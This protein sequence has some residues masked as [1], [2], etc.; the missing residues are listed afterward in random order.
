MKQTNVSNYNLFW[1]FLSFS[2]FYSMKNCFLISHKCVFALSNPHRLFLKC[3]QVSQMLLFVRAL[4]FY[5][6]LH[7]ELPVILRCLVQICLL[8]IPSAIKNTLY[9]QTHSVSII[10]STYRRVISARGRMSDV[11]TFQLAAQKNA[12]S[13]SKIQTSWFGA[14]GWMRQKASAIILRRVKKNLDWDAAWRHQH[15]SL[16]PCHLHQP[17]VNRNLFHCSTHPTISGFYSS[18][19][20]PPPN[21]AVICLCFHLFM[22]D[23]QVVSNDV[24]AASLLKH[25]RVILTFGRDFISES[26]QCSGSCQGDYCVA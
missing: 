6:E 3:Q 23:T 10:Q 12:L 7:G 21:M 13:S 8:K 4:T 16:S 19:C 22:P 5:C 24:F 18:Q 14:G 20:D 11:F 26:C 2:A 9:V 25:W 17:S 1:L 15:S